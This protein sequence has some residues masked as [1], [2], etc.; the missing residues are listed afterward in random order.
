MFERKTSRCPPSRS[1]RSSSTFSLSSVT[2][3]EV[4]Q[5]LPLPPKAE[6]WMVAGAASDCLDG[7]RYKS[8][9]E[10]AELIRK[11]ILT[12]VPNDDPANKRYARE[13]GVT[14]AELPDPWRY[15]YWLTDRGLRLLVQEFQQP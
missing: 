15:G 9:P 2:A 14:V 1:R 5:H 8:D 4:E 3:H 6:Q 11:R 7:W 13:L 10:I 12:I